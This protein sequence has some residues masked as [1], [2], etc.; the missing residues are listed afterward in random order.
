MEL[1]EFITSTIVE[2]SKGVIEAQEQLKDTGCI[3]NPQVFRTDTNVINDD[4]KQSFR[5]IQKLKITAVLSIAEVEGSNAK[6]GIAKILQAGFN[7]E[8]SNSHQKLNTIE[9]EIPIALPIMNS[10]I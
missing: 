6:I 10:K 7:L 9:F 5:A 1:K 3:I 8:T 4:Y 2:I